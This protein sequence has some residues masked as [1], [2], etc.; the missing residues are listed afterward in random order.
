MCSCNAAINEFHLL[1][2]MQAIN[3]SHISFDGVEYC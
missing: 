1:S 2:S 3:N